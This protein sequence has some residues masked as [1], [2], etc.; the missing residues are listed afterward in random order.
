MQRRFGTPALCS[1]LVLVV[2]F[3]SS[4]GISRVGTIPRGTPD[5]GNG[6]LAVIPT[7]SPDP[8]VV[9]PAPANATG[10]FYS[11]VRANQ[12]WVTLNG[13]KPV[14]VTNFDFTSV[15]NVFWYRPVWSKGDH[16][17]AF[18]MAA[19][20]MG[21][22]GGGCP[23]PDYGAN[24]NLYL[25]NTETK[26][27]T[28]IAFPSILQNVQMKGTPQNDYW[29]YVF[30]EDATHLLAWY[31]DVTGKVSSAAGLYRYDINTQ[32]LTQV[33]PLSVLGSATLSSPQKNMPLLISL[34]YSNGQLFY[35]VVVHPF[36]QQS[37]VVIYRH[38]VSH[39]EMQSS[40]I[41]QIGTEPWCALPQSGPYIKPG[42]DISS[43][44]E[45]LV[46]QMITATSSTQAVG[47]IQTLNLEDGS[48]TALFAQAPVDLLGQDL[49][50]MWG[51]DSQTVVA[52][53]S[54][55]LTPIG[56][57]S[58]SL[59]DPA[60]MQQYTPNLAGQVVWRSDSSA[61]AL[62]NAETVDQTETPNVYVFF[63][64]DTRGRMLLTDA[65]EFSW[66]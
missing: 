7:G 4:C 18:I 29:Q 44:G 23:G 14:Q 27:F 62:Q 17:I 47:T 32:K 53:A 49:L 55:M 65:L 22:G 25:M 52:T 64:G 54:H 38:S 50:L 41:L 8:L 34:R 16:Y 9:P 10:A 24:G 31:N 51:P 12:L 48:T 56:P 63:T 15:P 36:E 59:A 35:Q 66:G 37:Q 11:F 3:L 42:W 2:I 13:T 57:Y 26:Q 28:R 45:Q 40:K 46:T 19:R 58:A 60:A 39:P 43:N 61:F 1:L 20:P 6:T 33:I 5:T 30:W 21:L